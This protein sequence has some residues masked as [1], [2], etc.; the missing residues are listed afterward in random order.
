MAAR[1]VEERAD[2]LDGNRYEILAPSAEALEAE[3]PLAAV[4]LWRPMILFALE[5]KRTTRYRYAGR[6]F[7]S[8]AEADARIENYGNHP[9]H[10]D[11]EKK[12]REEHGRK[13]GFWSET[14]S[15]GRDGKMS[16]R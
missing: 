9:D 13:S 7:L 16:R 14:I 2:E 4:L 5:K 3:H 12:L 1:L 6:H 8:C 11:F 10:A 15:I